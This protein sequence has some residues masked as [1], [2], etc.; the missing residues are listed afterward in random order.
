MAQ[1]MYAGDLY[2]DGSTKD[3]IDMIEAT[4]GIAKNIKTED[5]QKLG[6]E[7]KNIQSSDT[8]TAVTQV[9]TDVVTNISDVNKAYNDS[10]NKASAELN[11]ISDAAAKIDLLKSGKID[12][13]N[14]LTGEHVTKEMPVKNRRT[15]STKRKISGRI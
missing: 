6:D 11:N 1:D 9:V 7:G 3:K 8:N 14:M 15:G 2:G 10:F 4:K 5:L 13:Y 12:D